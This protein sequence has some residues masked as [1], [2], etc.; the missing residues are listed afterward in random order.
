[1][2]NLPSVS[3]PSSPIRSPSY[4]A[5]SPPSSPISPSYGR[6]SPTRALLSPRRQAPQ[7]PTSTIPSLPPARLPQ[8]TQMLAGNLEGQSGGEGSGSEDQGNLSPRGSFLM[9]SPRGGTHPP[10]KPVKKPVSSTSFNS[11]RK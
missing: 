7:K 5:L 3:P 10:A 8:V 1:M 11:Y 4:K 2:T 9:I 6:R